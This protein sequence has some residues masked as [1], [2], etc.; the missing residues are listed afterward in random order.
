MRMWLLALGGSLAL[1]AC[2]QK[3]PLYLPDRNPSVVGGVPPPAQ[4][5]VAVPA[6]APQPQS[7]P[8]QTVPGTPAPPLA[9]PVQ[10][11]PSSDAHTGHPSKGDPDESDRP[12]AR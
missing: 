10:E 5:R 12:S 11:P 9:V 7:A 8:E 2:G 4:S 3:G 1:C 6:P